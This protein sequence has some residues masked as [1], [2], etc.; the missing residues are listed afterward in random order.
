MFMIEPIE[1]YTS[2]ISYLLSMM[3]AVRNSTMSTV[4]GLSTAQLD[5]LHD[6]QSNS[7]GMLL[8]H[9]ASLE[10]AYLVNTFEGRSLTSAEKERWNVAIRLGEPAR[11][12]I[13]GNDLDYYKDILRS[14]RQQTMDQFKRVDD[15]WLLEIDEYHNGEPINRYFKWFH[16][17]EDELN[18][19]GQI[20]WLKKRAVDKG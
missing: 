5:Y 19:R 13:K 15:N 2:Q 9:I 17:F 12:A 6:E 3:T 1:G 11:R 10:Y 18:H 20:R 7:I 14:V 8:L 4:H 16:V